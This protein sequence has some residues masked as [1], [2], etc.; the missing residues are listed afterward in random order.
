MAQSLGGGI[1]RYNQRERERER[2]LELGRKSVKSVGKEG[3]KR[4]RARNAKKYSRTPIMYCT[5]YLVTM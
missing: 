2:E 1:E 3:R 5:Y 4:F